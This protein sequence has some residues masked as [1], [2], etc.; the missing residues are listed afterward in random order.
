MLF[1]KYCR[2]WNRGRNLRCDG[3]GS[4]TAPKALP[5]SSSSSLLSLQVTGLR[6]SLGLKKLYRLPSVWSCGSFTYGLFAKYL[7]GWIAR[8][9]AFPGKTPVSVP[10]GAVSRSGTLNPTPSA[11]SGRTSQPQ[12]CRGLG[13]GFSVAETEGICAVMAEDQPLPEKLSDH[14]EGQPPPQHQTPRW[15][16]PASCLMLSASSHTRFFTHQSASSRRCRA[17][18]AHVRQSRPD[19]GLLFQPKS[20][21][22]FDP[23]PEAVDDV[24]EILSLR[25]GFRV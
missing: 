5:S 11:I 7:R 6:R 15:S 8:N 2:S 3:R 23:R 9:L 22:L 21:K 12:G 18:T 20:Y 25:L 10:P 4:T 19:S 16:A 24:E 13:I 1:A 17:K 14:E